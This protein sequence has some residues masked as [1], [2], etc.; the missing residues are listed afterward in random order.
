M[1]MT[2]APEL[3]ALSDIFQKNGF[4]LY[5]VGGAVR[6]YVLGKPSHD[7]DFT[8]DA[9]PMEVKSMF[10]RTIDTGIKHG[11]V[12][13]LF[14]GGSYEI[15]TFR[16]EGDYSDSRHP[17][18]VCFVRSLEED[19]KRR[20]FTINALASNV[21]DGEIIDMHEGLS[22]L[23]N[24]TIRAIG[25]P[26]ERF[27]E[28][29]LRMMRAARFSAK[30]GFSIEG[31]T[32]SAMKALKENI[33]NISRERIREEFFR[34]VDSPFPRMGLEAM[35]KSGLMEI[36]FPELWET[37][38]IEGHGYHKENLYEHLVLSLEAARDLGAPVT[39]KLA[40]LFHDI[41]KT[42]TEKRD[43]DKWTYYH[44]EKVGEEM[45]RAIMTRL[46]SSNEERD[47]VCL[48]IRE[49][50]FLYSPLWS[51][52][53]VRRLI[54]RVGKENLDNLF[55]LREADRK[56]TTALPEEVS[57]DGLKERIKAELSS[58]AALTLK[59]LKINGKDLLGIVEKG[60]EMGRVL[61]LLLEMVIDDP[62]K[63][64]REI[65]LEKAREIEKR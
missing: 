28:D 58:S 39:V 57:D 33:R 54:V 61:S 5:L 32:L 34:L 24:G 13:V 46:K 38:R 49:H 47:Q 26:M 9:L 64:E 65:L 40:A 59:D 56:A 60:P 11:T 48:F 31:N 43:G 6:D 7:Y 44:H 62:G 18:N 17:D 23:K 63:N 53:S 10:R 52:G 21:Q 25:N 50:M 41:G 19:L 20:D 55:L 42:A 22:D 29:G 1:K 8:T 51:D 37:R 35:E 36:L 45:A 14:K 12:T 27:K 16:T 3:K 15:T 30:L 2:V 4:S